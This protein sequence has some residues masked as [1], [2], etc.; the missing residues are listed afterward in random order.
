LY[1]SLVVALETSNADDG[2][3]GDDGEDMNG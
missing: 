1:A 3:D 2:D